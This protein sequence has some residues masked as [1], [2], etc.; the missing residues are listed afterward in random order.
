MIKLKGTTRPHI[1]RNMRVKKIP[2]LL[3]S[4]KLEYFIYDKKVDKEYFEGALWALN[5]RRKIVDEMTNLQSDPFDRGAQWTLRKL[6]G[7]E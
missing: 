3:R 7:L 1:R 5:T 4:P 2:R 6:R